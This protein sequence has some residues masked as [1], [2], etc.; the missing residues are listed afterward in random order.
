[1]FGTPERLPAL[2]AP[3]S[4]VITTSMVQ[5]LNEKIADVDCM[6]DALIIHCVARIVAVP[7]NDLAHL[8]ALLCYR[9]QFFD[10]SIRNIYSV[11]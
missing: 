10:I 5:Y 9:K 2:G 7:K 3:F 1:M 8:I 11:V 4:T 6:Y